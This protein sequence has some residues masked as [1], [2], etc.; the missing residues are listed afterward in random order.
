MNA[1]KYSQ[2]AA[3]SDHKYGTQCPNHLSTGSHDYMHPLFP[4]SYSLLELYP[5]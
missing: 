5:D 2:C 1:Q 4:H 3:G